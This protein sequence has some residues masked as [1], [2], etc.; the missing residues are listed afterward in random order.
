MAHPRL[1]GIIP[2][3]LTPFKKDSVAYDELAENIKKWSE[4]GVIGFLVF[5]STGEYVYLTEEEKIRLVETVV[6]AAPEGMTI[7]AGTGM[8]STA[9]TIRLTKVCAEKGAQA[10]LV[11]TPCYYGGRMTGEA[12]AAHFS[13]VADASPIPIMLYNVPPFTNF[14]MKVST[15]VQLSHH[16][17]IIGIKDSLGNVMQLG[18][19]L[20][21]AAPDFK[22][23]TGSG[24]VV[25]NALTLGCEGAI[26]ALANVAPR[27]CVKIYNLVKEGR[28]DE[29]RDLQ[30]KLLPVN[31]AMTATYGIP[32]AKYALDRLGYY[33]GPPRPPLLPVSRADKKKIDAILT[34]AGLL[35]L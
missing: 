10:A 30:L 17:N 6:A 34:R 11:V 31:T 15:I 26:L 35:N 8:E 1:D 12:L 3:I 14:N 20:N 29:A 28:Y 27:G 32:G 4:T 9:A 5:G 18:A 23:L 16:P 33:G 25:F 19:M 24:G 7:L 21:K 2:A 13:A 22:I